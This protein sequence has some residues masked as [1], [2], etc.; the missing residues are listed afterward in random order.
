MEVLL[1]KSDGLP[2]LV[3]DKKQLI[4][5][6]ELPEAKKKEVSPPKE[7]TE[8]LLAAGAKFRGSRQE[9]IFFKV[10]DCMQISSKNYNSTQHDFA[11]FKIDGFK[12]IVPK[13]KVGVGL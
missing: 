13:F 4:I 7:A 1:G 11:Y 5:N 10:G 2:P 12:K 6:T 3:L 8:E 9:D